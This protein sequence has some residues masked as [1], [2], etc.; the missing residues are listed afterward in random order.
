LKQIHPGTSISKEAVSVVD[1][2]VKDLFDR[3]GE[4]CHRLKQQH[5]SKTLSSY[6]IQTVGYTVLASCSLSCLSASQPYTSYSYALTQPATH[7]YGPLCALDN[8]GIF[9][10][11]AQ[12]TRLLLQGELAKHA[13]AEGTKAVVAFEKY[14]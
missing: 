5:T 3:F 2:F 13:V 9:T 4:E 11:S 14:Q 6:D 12:A 1:S 10:L 8:H 7:G